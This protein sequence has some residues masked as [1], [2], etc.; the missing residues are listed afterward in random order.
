MFR[1]LSYIITGSE[2][3]HLMLRSAIVAHMVSI[4]HLLSGIGPDG[5]HN[6]LV[7]YGY[8]SIEE[9]L[10]STNMATKGSWGS[11]VEMCVLAHLLGTPM[12]PFQGSD[13]WLACFPHALDRAINQDIR[14]KSMYIYLRSSHFEV[15]TSIRRRAT[16]S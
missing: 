8:D 14:C 1:A 2:E 7:S 15:V 13:Y 3:E 11:D 12:Y 4:P 16:D 6:Y 5:L 10:A 9:Y